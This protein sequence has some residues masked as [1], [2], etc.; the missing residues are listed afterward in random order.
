MKGNGQTHYM[1]QIKSSYRSIAL[2]LAALSAIGPFAVDTYLPS[3]KNIGES[4]QAGPLEVQQTLTAYLLPFAIMSLWHGAISD[5]L[6]RRRVVLVSIA[7]FTVAV[8]GCVFATRIEHLW[9]LRAIQGMSAGAGVVV[10]RAVVRDLFDGPQAQRL[11]SQMTMM[12]AFAPA[13]APVIGGQLQAM[14][15]W[16]SIFVFLMGMSILLWLVCWKFLPETLAVEKRQ[17]LR[18]GYLVRAYKHVLTSGR[19]L[20]AC[21][22]V[23]FNFAAYFI[24]IMA[25]PVFLIQHLGMAETQFFWMFG[26]SMLGL[27]C[28]AWTS[29]YLAGKIPVKKTIIRGYLIMLLAASLNL[30]ISFFLPPSPIWSIFPLFIYTFGMSIVAPCLTLL[31]LDPFPDHRGLASSCQMFVQTL[32]NSFVAGMLAPLLWG[33]TAMLATGMMVL[34]LLGVFS[35]AIYYRIARKKK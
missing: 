32:F 13:I 9:I 15:G 17:S 7:L 29:G 2:T 30:A 24:Y 18:P 6:G 23:V 16:R 3:L 21:G 28:G 11:M 33:T 22:G 10:S 19:F 31:T 35:T 27:L 25:S 1:S 26:P 14:F 4:L 34:L 8:A 5:A 12:F 20:F